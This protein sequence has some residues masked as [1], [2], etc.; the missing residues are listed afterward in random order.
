[1]LGP[2]K[3][4]RKREGK[5][6]GKRTGKGREGKKGKAG[7]RGKGEGRAKDKEREVSCRWVLRAVPCCAVPGVLPARAPSWMPRGVL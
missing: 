3:G 5:R 4:R 6:E 7:E 1:M 2:G